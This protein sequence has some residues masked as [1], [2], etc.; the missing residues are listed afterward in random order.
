MLMNAIS[1]LWLLL[2]YIFLGFIQGFTEPIPISSSGHL[3]I[4]RQ[5]FDINIKGLSFEILVNFGSL[6]AIILVYR[7]DIIAIL[8]NAIQYARN[9]DKHRKSDFDFL[10]LLIVA[11]FIT[12]ILGLFFEDYISSR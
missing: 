4:I 2:K 11:T 3:V 1:E 5:L 10:I 6:I 8:F 9:K 12:G 7:R